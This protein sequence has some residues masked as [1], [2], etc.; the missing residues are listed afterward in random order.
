MEALFNVRE[1]PF[2]EVRVEVWWHFE[3]HHVPPVFVPFHG[4]SLQSIKDLSAT[5]QG[6]RRVQGAVNRRPTEALASLAGNGIC[7]HQDEC[8]QTCMTSAKAKPA[9]DLRAKTV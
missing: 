2:R 6:K 4:L 3:Y 5:E 9:K 8:E 7:S 1:K